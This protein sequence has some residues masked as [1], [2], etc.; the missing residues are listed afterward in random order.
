MR[1]SNPDAIYGLRATPQ[2]VP[3]GPF[4]NQHHFAAFM[5]MTAGVALAFLFGKGVSRDRKLLL[6]LAVIVMGAAVV[7]TSSRGGLIGF[8]AVFAL[9]LIL[10]YL[11]ARSD[12]SG[13]QSKM[14]IAATSVGIMII[15]FGL[16]LYLGGNESLLR[17]MG[18][19]TADVDI[20]TG[21]LHFWPVA[22]RIFLDHPIF[23]AGFDSFGVAFTQYDTWNGAFRVEQAHNDYLQTLAD[24]GITGFVCIA[25]FILLLFKK[26]LRAFANSE[27]DFRRNAVIGSLAGC[28]G[29]LIHSFFDFPLRTPS[30][31]FFFLMLAAI[32]TVPIQLRHREKKRHKRKATAP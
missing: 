2:S 5:E 20:S 15:I 22:L 24:S 27:N 32:A 8:T 12:R 6:M 18:I 30:N 21:R 9:V 28:F 11:A 7:F 19:A 23:G 31:A 4:V 10:T 26:A 25:A 3:F 17:G 1:L 14:A 13:I 29:L 16:V